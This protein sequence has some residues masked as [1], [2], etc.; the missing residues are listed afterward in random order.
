[1]R[2]IYP[3]NSVFTINKHSTNMIMFSRAERMFPL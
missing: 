3:G 2:S 1:M